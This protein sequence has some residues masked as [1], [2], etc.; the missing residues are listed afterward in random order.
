MNKKLIIISIIII[1]VLAGTYGIGT[2]ISIHN[3]KVAESKKSTFDSEP[4]TNANLGHENKLLADPFSKIDVGQLYSYNS[5]IS[6]GGAKN[7]LFSMNDSGALI[8]SGKASDFSTGKFQIYGDFNFDEKEVKKVTFDGLVTSGANA[9]I[10]FYL[11]GSKDPFATMKLK[12]PV[13]GKKNTGTEYY[14]FI[15]ELKDASSTDATSGEAEDPS[16]TGLNTPGEVIAELN[17]GISGKH[18]ITLGFTVDSEKDIDMEI[19][20]RS[21]QFSE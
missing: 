8:I 18:T 9:S 2:A 6:E 3:K 10:D 19:L 20:M 16:V 15:P 1:V 17:E 5:L 7:L 12:S 4:D 13:G 21:I 11:D 14:E